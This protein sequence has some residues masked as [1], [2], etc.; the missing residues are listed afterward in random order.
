M[1][2]P[3]Q[4]PKH[5]PRLEMKSTNVILSDFWYSE[6]NEWTFINVSILIL[7]YYPVQLKPQNRGSALQCLFPRRCRKAHPPQTN[8]CFQSGIF[9]SGCQFRIDIEIW[10]REKDLLSAN[11]KLLFFSQRADIPLP[12]GVQTLRS[13]PRN[14]KVPVLTLCKEAGCRCSPVEGDEPNPG[15]DPNWER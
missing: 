12:L 8:I 11:Q 1:L 2:N 6:W 3:R 9:F 13:V 15:E 7:I 4:S 10:T 14:C 5:P